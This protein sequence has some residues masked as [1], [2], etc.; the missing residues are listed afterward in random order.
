MRL[1]I[2]G[3]IGAAALAL[4]GCQATSISMVDFQSLYSPSLVA[5]A[6]KDGY[7]P[8]ALY[9]QPVAGDKAAIDAAVVR[10]LRIPAHFSQV[11]IQATA[12]A[13]QGEGHR[14]V[15]LFDPQPQTNG[16]RACARTVPPPAP[17]GPTLRV[18]AVF[19]SGDGWASEGLAAMPRPARADAPELRDAINTLLQIVLPLRNPHHDRDNDQYDAGLRFA[20][21]KAG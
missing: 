17:A 4:T 15:L 3:A 18:R 5:Y 1:R 8:V 11:P 10:N 21:R 19:C 14:L 13:Q 9:G 2:F 20:P 12:E 16:Y 7:L 6:S